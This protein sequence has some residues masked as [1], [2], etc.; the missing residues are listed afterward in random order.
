MT[1]K[2]LLKSFGYEEELLSK[3]TEED[4]EH[5]LTE[6]KTGGHQ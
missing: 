5:E 3:M 6:I 1:A 2:E 4:C